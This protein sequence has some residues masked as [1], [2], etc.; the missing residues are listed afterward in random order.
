M[1]GGRGG[2]MEGPLIELVLIVCSLID[3]GECAIR[4]PAFEPVYDSV[5]ACAV[6]GQLAAV[7]WE[8]EHPDW[9]VRRWTCGAPKA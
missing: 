2:G 5:R 3:P 4:R 9:T 8:E 7:R 1:A 6:Q